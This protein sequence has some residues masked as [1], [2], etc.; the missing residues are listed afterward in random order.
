MKS[1]ASRKSEQPPGLDALRSGAVPGVLTATEHFRRLEAAPPVPPKLAVDLLELGHCERRVGPEGATVVRRLLFTPDRHDVLGRWPQP[2]A[3]IPA[4][5]LRA[6]SPDFAGMA[7]LPLH[8]IAFLDTETTG[9]AGGSGT[10]AFLI[11][12]GWWDEQGF[13]LEQYL[14]EDFVHEPDQLARVAETLCRF[15]ALCTYNGRTFDI[16]LLRSR[17]VMGRRHCAGLS[18]PHLDLL[19]F[20]RRLWRG[21]LPNCSLKT[22]EREALGIDRGEDIDGAQVP[23]LFFEA[24]RSGSI[25][26]LAPVLAHNAQDVATLAALLP[27]L[28]QVAGDPLGN[29]RVKRS[30]E[31]AGIARWLESV[32]NFDM[33]ATA[34]ERSIETHDGLDRGEEERLLLRLARANKRGKRWEEAVATWQQFLRRPLHRSAEAW[35]ELAKY[36]EHVARDPAAALAIVE[37]ALRQAQLDEDLAGLSGSGKLDVIAALRHDFAQRS[38]RLRARVGRLSGPR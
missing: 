21:T 2:S 28:A 36:H 10:L 27:W 18:L 20:S 8:R 12:I 11:A 1:L 31:W 7:S 25:R 14:V 34:W 24:A 17:M 30:G 3:E 5:A 22:V 37:R 16:P 13:Q 33:A 6:L 9:L 15:D 26:C 29:D 32:K 35:V 4:A 19:G 23:A 38:A